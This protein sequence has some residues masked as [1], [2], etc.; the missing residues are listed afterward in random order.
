MSSPSRPR[1]A[2]DRGKSWRVA[3]VYA[4]GIGKG[5]TAVKKRQTQTQ[6]AEATSADRVGSFK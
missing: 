3:K 1:P 2:F 4:E 6:A 5:S